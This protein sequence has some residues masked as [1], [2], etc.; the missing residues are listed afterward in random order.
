MA[1]RNKL[2]LLFGIILCLFVS[3]VF[4]AG[5]AAQKEALDVIEAFANKL[6][7]QVKHEGSTENVELSGDAKIELS[8][9]LKKIADLGI[10]GAAK[11]QKSEYQGVLQKDL[12]T[13]IQQGV[14][15]KLK[16]WNDL[17]DKL[18][19]VAGLGEGTKTKAHSTAIGAAY[20]VEC[21]DNKERNVFTA[22]IQF[23][24]NH[25]ARWRYTGST[26]WNE[27]L[28]VESLSPHKV[29]LSHF[30]SDPSRHTWD[31]EFSEDFRRVRGSYKFIQKI[32]PPTRW[33]DYE[34]AGSR[35][36]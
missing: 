33:R 17:K 14:D 10:E 5:L 9:L 36:E 22:I 8:N 34:V 30:K 31:L 7:T 24:S 23:T 28:Q 12:T 13:L 15:C 11:Y 35:I 32:P 26:G 4:A 21:R 2:S 18:I 16:V 3:T 25:E 1:R 6:C 20:E 29:L 19:P 27:P